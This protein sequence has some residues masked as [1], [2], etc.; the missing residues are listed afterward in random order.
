MEITSATPLQES[1]RKH[2]LRPYM[3]NQGKDFLRHIDNATHQ[4]ARLFY[5]APPILTETKRTISEGMT[6]LYNG[7]PIDFESLRD[8]DIGLPGVQAKTVNSDGVSSPVATLNK[9][10]DGDKLTKDLKT[11]DVEY[12]WDKIADGNRYEGHYYMLLSAYYHNQIREW[13]TKLLNDKFKLGDKTPQSIDTVIAYIEE[14]VVKDFDKPT[15]KIQNH[16]VI[17]ID[18]Y[19]LSNWNDTIAWKDKG[20]I[21]QKLIEGAGKTESLKQLKQMADEK[22]LSFLY[23]APNTKPVVQTCIDL[24]LECYQDLGS[25]VADTS[26]DGQPIHRFLGIC[27]PSIEK[28]DTDYEPGEM[29]PIKYDIVAMDEIEQLLMFGVDGGGCVINPQKANGILRHFVEKANLVVGMDARL[30]NLTLT[31][32]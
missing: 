5:M 25:K 1:D 26:S 10:I 21:L 11:K 4:K 16:N 17:D 27:Y 2:L 3:K 28:Y 32:T 6:C 13:R 29:S 24:G 20:V 30:S 31:S 22:G 7:E 8:F 23:I 12:W 15:D 18:T 19:R 14:N 9:T